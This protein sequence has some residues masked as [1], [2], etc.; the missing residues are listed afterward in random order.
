VKNGRILL[1]AVTLAGGAASAGADVADVER[2]MERFLDEQGVLMS[3]LR[4]DFTPYVGDDPPGVESLTLPGVSC[5]KGEFRTYENSG[6]VQGAFLAAMCAK[7]RA[8]GSAEALA[9]ADRTYR[10]I[11][12]IYDLSRPGGRG[13]YCK[14]WGGRCQD[15]TSSDQYV[16]TLAGLVAYEK[17]VRDG[18][19]RAE[20]RDMIVAMCDFWRLRAYE[21]KYYT[22]PLK[23]QRCRFVSFAAWG[24]RFEK[25]H[26][27]ADE[28]K[29]LLADPAVTQ[30][31]PFRAS[32]EMNTRRAADGGILYALNGECAMSGFLSVWSALEDD[33]ACAYARQLLPHFHRQAVAAL[34][35]DGTGYVFVTKNADGT[36]SEMDPRRSSVR[37]PDAKPPWDWLFFG[38]TAPY[39]HGGQLSATA[40]NALVQMAPYYRPSAD[41]TAAHAQEYL[42][43]IADGHFTWFEDPHGVLP[44]S[45]KWMTDVRSGDAVANWLWAYWTIRE[46]GW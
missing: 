21:Y 29:R 5:T 2:T 11:R 36:F 46:R 9:K 33:P 8:T 14:P 42:N 34:A 13:F 45:L 28:L 43:K 37:R 26:G 7:C 23:W 38:V 12:R 30:D 3:H 31:I 22:S 27:C 19:T 16:Y 20:I 17:L 6:M 35:P 25:G 44:A 32:P 1:F 4:K 24:A 10:G 15:E 40:V 41:W 18:K 39:R